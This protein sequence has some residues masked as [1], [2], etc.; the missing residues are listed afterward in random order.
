[1]LLPEL[2][3]LDSRSI[4]TDLGEI[5]LFGVVKNE[6]LRLPYFLDYYRRAGVAQF[7]I[8]DNDSTDGTTAFLLQQPDC[9]VFHTKASYAESR[10][11]VT[12]L[13][14]LLDLYGAGHWIVLADADEL[15]T[16]PLGE[17]RALPALCRWLDA[18]DYQGVFALLLDMYSDRPLK[19]IRY[20]RGDDLLRVCRY[21]D[22]DYHFVRRLGV[23]LIAPAFPGIEP[24][25]GPRL[26]LCFPTQNTA[27][28]WPRLRVKIV[29]RL[30]RLAVKSGLVREAWGESVATQAFKVPLVR[31]RHGYAFINSHRLNCIRLAPIT[32]A[33]LHFKYLQ[34]FSG[35]VQDAIASGMHYDGSA[36]YKQ[37]AKLLR[38]DPEMS[39]VYSGSEIYRS[40]NDLVRLKL[41][42]TDPEWELSCAA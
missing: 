20:A 32:G 8:V 13:N 35:R 37:Y 41:I 24:I 23:P 9:C 2:T 27:A 17:E 1:M 11:G 38:R 36:E 29:R 6:S 10:A 28:M 15:F 39:M 21:F 26:R 34:D 18:R 22:R 14:C 4:S 3:R 25:G 31:W 5:R 12:W 42:K 16:Y 30:T 33:L 7:F 19:Q 40:S